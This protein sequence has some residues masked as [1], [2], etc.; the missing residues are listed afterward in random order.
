MQ[1]AMQEMAVTVCGSRVLIIG[2]GRVAKACS[3][4]FLAAGAD[5]ACTAR[6]LS[7]LADAENNG[8]R[9]FLLGELYGRIDSFDLII[10]TVPH[11]IL[12]KAML[13]AAAKDAVIIDLASAP[14]GVDQ[15]AAAALNKRCIHAL[16]LPGKVAPITAGEIIAKTVINI[17]NERKG[18]E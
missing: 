15:N 13:S 14:G 1:I 6:R 17:I 16:S 7:A 10:N 8:C 9:A 12:D 4:L 3:R 2:Y 18:V 5:V 11:L